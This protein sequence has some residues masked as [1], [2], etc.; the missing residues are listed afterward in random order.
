MKIV[1]LST[2]DKKKYRAPIG[3]LIEFKKDRTI[4]NYLSGK[5]FVKYKSLSKTYGKAYNFR[6]DG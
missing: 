5:K 1:V 2:K 3:T 4:Y 6:S